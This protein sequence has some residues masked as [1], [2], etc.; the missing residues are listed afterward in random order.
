[1]SSLLCNFLHHPPSSRL[2]SNLLNAPVLKN[3]Q[4]YI[5]PLINDLIA[6]RYRT[7]FEKL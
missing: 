6:P 5:T 7:L 3:P 2:D 1:V 4:S